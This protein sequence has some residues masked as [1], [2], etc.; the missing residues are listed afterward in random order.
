MR[1]KLRIESPELAALPWEYLYDGNRGDYLTLSAST[2]VVRYIP[3][4]Q[5]MAPLQVQPPL[6]ILAMVVSPRHAPISTSSANGNGS[7][8]RF[9]G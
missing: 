5:T 8:P 7:I 3:L 1:I 2:P 4:P 6:R 9:R